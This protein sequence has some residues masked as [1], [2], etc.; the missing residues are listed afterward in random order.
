MRFVSVQFG[1]YLSNDLWLRTSMHSLSMAKRL[2][3]GIKGIDSVRVTQPVESNAVFATLSSDMI[4]KLKSD[5]FFYI[6]DETNQEVRWMTSFDT[7]PDDVD[8]FVSL[9]KKYSN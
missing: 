8:H 5:Y 9:I 1:T 2:A 4:K 6:W 7:T 3:D